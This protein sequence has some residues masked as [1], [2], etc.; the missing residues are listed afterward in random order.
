[1][2]LLCK[3]YRTIS[4]KSG[5]ANE[6]EFKLITELAGVAKVSLQKHKK[7][8]AQLKANDQLTDTHE[9]GIT[10]AN[11][12]SKKDYERLYNKSSEEKRAE[13]DILEASEITYE[14]DTKTKIKNL[15]HGAEG[16]T[17]ADFDE[18]NPTINLKVS[19]FETNTEATLSDELEHAYQFEKGEIGYKKTTNQNGVIKEEAIGYD[20]NDE[21]KSK[22]DYIETAEAFGQTLPP[23]IQRIKDIYDDASLSMEER[24]RLLETELKDVGY[25]FS[26]G[27]VD[28]QE[29]DGSKVGV[30]IPSHEGNSEIFYEKNRTIRA[31]LY[32]RKNEETNEM[33]TQYVNKK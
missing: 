12:K 10:F 2:F 4:K 13:L 5:T 32:R 33:E 9:T 3:E 30:D 29:L 14:I 20:V 26:T 7:E 17:T 24:N 28:L 22:L 21:L 8:Q 23:S 31:A 15:P 19:W 6:Q 16:H 18:E 27:V 25:D 1:M 11:R